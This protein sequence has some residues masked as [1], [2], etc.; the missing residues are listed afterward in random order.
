MCFFETNS[1]HDSDPDITSKY[2]NRENIYSTH[3]GE[4]VPP[5]LFRTLGRPSDRNTQ[6]ALNELLVIGV[7][8]RTMRVALSSVDA[9]FYIL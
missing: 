3:S 5:A 7:F 2:V 1:L 6:T 4:Y 8:D 9:S